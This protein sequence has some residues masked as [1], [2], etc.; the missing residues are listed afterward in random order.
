VLRVVR[1][2]SPEVFGHLADAASSL[3]AALRELVGE[4][5]ASP[6]R[7]RRGGVEHIDLG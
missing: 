4:A 1:G 7:E 5:S 6:T 3:S 2:A